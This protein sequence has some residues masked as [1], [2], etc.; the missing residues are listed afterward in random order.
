MTTS[1]KNQSGTTGGPAATRGFLVQALVALLEMARPESSFT[2]ITLEPMEGNDQFDFMWR[3][4][5]GS[6]AT[7]VKSTGNSFTKGDVEGWARKLKEVRT[8]EECT[9]VLVGNIPPGLV[10][11]RAIDGVK[12]ETKNLDLGAFVEQAAQR[13]AK[14]LESENLPSGKALQREMVVD[15]LT[16]RLQRHAT[17]SRPLSR[18]SFLELLREWINS[19]PKGKTA[20]DLSHFEVQKYAPSKL[21][22]RE[23]ETQSLNCAWLQVIRETKPRFHIFTFVAAGGEGKTSL[24]AKWVADLAAQDWTGC[25]GAFAWS[26]YSQGASDQNAAS[27]D[28]FLKEALNFF[29]NDED[30]QY[31]AGSAGAFEKGQR[32]ARI[33]GERRSL[34]I[35]DGLEPLQY[36][37]TSPMPGELKDQGIAALLKGLAADSRGLCI[38]TTRYSLPD[39]RAYWQTTAPEEPLLR[40]SKSAGVD[41]LQKLGVRKESGTRTEFEKLVEDVKGHAL[42]L[43][44]LGTYLRDAHGGDI[45]K[46]DL[47]K[48]EEA[49]VEEQAGHA[50][51]VMDAYVKAL[52]GEGEKGKQALAMLRL[53]GL[54]DRPAT[55]DCLGALWRSSAIAGLTDP[56]VGMSEA[57]R[58]ITFKRLQD[59]RLLTVNYDK[60]GVLLSLDA[61]PLLREYFAKQ[62]REQ[63]PDA[64]RKAHRRVYEH[65]CAS[66]PDKPAPTLEDLQPLY[67]AVA[68]GCQAGLQQEVVDKVYV[69]RI[70][71]GREAYVV[72]KLGAYG[73]DLGAVACFFEQPWSRVSSLLTEA[74]QAW[75]LSQAAFGLRALGRL[76]EALE[77]MRVAGDL[78]VKAER[79]Q[80]AAIGS[81]NL[82]ELELTLGDV[83][84]A[85][86]DAEQ[87]VIYADSSGDVFQR[88]SRCAGHADALHQAGR[89]DKAE[90]LFEKAEQMQ[91]ERQSDYPLLYSLQGFQY[92]DLLLAA[93]E[94][95]AWQQILNSP[96]VSQQSSLVST[97]RSVSRRAGQTLEW[98]TAQHWLLDIALDYLTMGRAALYQAILE[99]SEIR[100]SKTEIEK[101]V[102]GLRRSGDQDHLPKALLTRAWLR[103]LTGADTGAE[104]AQG[105]LDEAWEIAERGGMKLHMADIHLYRARLFF[106]E[107][108]YPWESPKVDLA[109]A[110]ELIN[111]CGYHRRDEELKDA[112]GAIEDKAEG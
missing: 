3:D 25:D 21:I 54:F 104:S 90:K 24:V 23:D 9:L 56:L 69:A 45:R 26:F 111:K 110:E 77:P 68:H 48:L 74:A 61:H 101:A 66:T 88:M 97:C 72:N 105:D 70:M 100:N 52:E 39:L 64:W 53:M 87:S 60:S 12:I 102:E 55:A 96:L 67:Q 73:S 89:R 106:R 59:A 76:T 35:L 75:L 27:S 95:A 91:K 29:G 30:K 108:A 109:A 38:V 84:G 20:V 10:S 112:K 81:S 86:G 31:A 33:V 4:K 63:R 44:L 49:N 92:C 83:A 103:F 40:L 57:Q 8:D 62:L 93:V 47:V 5:N 85:V 41:L 18:E 99:K 36:P 1:N 94:R 19:V 79:W 22:G 50:F 82:S 6:Y 58:N 34:L 11:L 37:L 17:K 28:L 7:Q 80:N 32:L 16:T 13:L 51:R 71:R 42:T 14:F 15:A 78:A 107:R 46:R 2:E 43:N 98:V 65:L